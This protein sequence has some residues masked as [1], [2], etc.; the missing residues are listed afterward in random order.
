MQQLIQ[1]IVQTSV[2]IAVQ[3]AVVAALIIYQQ[4]Q[5]KSLNL[6][7]LSDQNDQDINKNETVFQ[8]VT[9]MQ[10]TSVILI[11]TLMLILSRFV[12]TNKFITIFSSL[13][14][15]DASRSLLYSQPHFR[16][17]SSHVY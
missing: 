14:T 4:N 5:Q 15:E 10:E 17:I 16:K 7:N 8:E 2:Q 11:Q 12:M 9:S 13:Q 1:E 3:N 6:L